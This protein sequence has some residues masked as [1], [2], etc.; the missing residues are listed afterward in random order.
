MREIMDH[1]IGTAAGKELYGK[2]KQTIEPVL[3][4][5]TEAMGFRRFRLRRRGKA[6]LKWTRVSER[7]IQRE[8]PST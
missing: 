7:Q 8:I 3:G 6:R 2:R 1:L 4:I 5:I